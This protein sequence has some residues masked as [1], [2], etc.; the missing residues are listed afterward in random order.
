MALKLVVRLAVKRKQA[1]DVRVVV[2]VGS[3]TAEEV[4]VLL[5]IPVLF[6]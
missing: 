3:S 6:R 4:L 2:I 5:I 1:V